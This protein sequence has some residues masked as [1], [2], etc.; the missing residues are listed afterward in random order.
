MKIELKGITLDSEEFEKCLLNNTLLPVCN[1]FAVHKPE[2]FTDNWIKDINEF[3]SFYSLDIAS[4]SY[5]RSLVFSHKTAISHEPDS[6]GRLFAYSTRSETFEINSDLI[7]AVSNFTDKA[8]NIRPLRLYTFRHD[9]FSTFITNSCSYVPTNPEF[10]SHPFAQLIHESKNLTSYVKE[11]QP[12]RLTYPHRVLLDSFG[13]YTTHQDRIFSERLEL[14]LV[15]GFKASGVNHEQFYSELSAFVS[16]DGDSEKVNALT[17]FLKSFSD[18]TKDSENDKLLSS[19]HLKLPTLF[20]DRPYGRFGSIGA[21]SGFINNPDKSNHVSS[22]YSIAHRGKH[23]AL[24]DVIPTLAKKPVNAYT[25]QMQGAPSRYQYLIIKSMQYGDK[26]LPNTPVVSFDKDLPIDISQY[27]PETKAFSMLDQKHKL[28]RKRHLLSGFFIN[29]ISDDLPYN[30]KNTAAIVEETA[31]KASEN[32]TEL[33]APELFKI[34]HDYFV[35]AKL[36]HELIEAL[37][38]FRDRNALHEAYSVKPKAPSLPGAQSKMPVGLEYLDGQV[39]IKP[40]DAFDDQRFTHI[41]KLPVDLNNNADDKEKSGLCALEF[42]GMFTAQKLG[43]EVPRFG[44]VSWPSLIKEL[45]IGSPKGD[46]SKEPAYLIER[47]D[48]TSDSNKSYILKEF[49]ALMGESDKFK[50]SQGK[51][52]TAESVCLALKK[53]STD[54][55]T[56]KYKLLR[57]FIV[58]EIIGNTDMHLKNI[59]MLEFRDNEKNL[60]SCKLSPSYDIA[61][62]DALNPVFFL[63]SNDPMNAKG[64]TYNGKVR[65]TVA[66]WVR[67]AETCLDISGDECLRLI[68]EIINKANLFIRTY[69]DRPV[70]DIFT[71]S[72]MLREQYDRAIRRL[73]LG[74][75][76]L[77]DRGCRRDA[78]HI[79]YAEFKDVWNKTFDEA[80]RDDAKSKVTLQAVKQSGETL[81]RSVQLGDQLLAALMLPENSGVQLDGKKY[82]PGGSNQVMISDAINRTII[83]SQQPTFFPELNDLPDFLRG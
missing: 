19:A 23:L 68:D 74:I 44:V 76:I 66:D 26:I 22:R 49:Q 67:I 75:K 30:A 40:S 36:S 72:S 52:H 38:F 62:V 81:N 39:Q 6:N 4:F 70:S 48:I 33:L 41:L 64:L 28:H 61:S 46:L 58:N 35:K 47:F 18:R 3:I 63:N 14:S 1:G 45:D 11:T 53:F 9:S 20:R 31:R 5:P 32:P 82:I 27:L 77:S 55:A 24:V 17:S 78:D 29:P 12:I 57:F 10:Q 73:S 59:A 65:P 7:A 56:D 79:P 60:V 16:S 13:K 42:L 69:A 8:V 71:K 51:P 54:F 50:D 34:D 15:L 25:R 21:V 43:L 83:D 37:R 80:Q 2:V